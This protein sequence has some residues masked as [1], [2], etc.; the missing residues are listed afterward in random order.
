MFVVIT[1]PREVAM[2]LFHFDNGLHLHDIDYKSDITKTASFLNEIADK[3]IE[4]INYYKNTFGDNCIVLRYEDAFYFQE[5]FLNQTSKFLDLKSLNVDDVRKYKRSIYKNV[6]DFNQFFDKEEL[7][8]HYKK[9]K[10]FYEEWE[11][12]EGGT[13][14]Q[15]YH[16][17]DAE[18]SDKVKYTTMLD[19]NGITLVSKCCF[20]MNDV[21]LSNRVKD[22]NEF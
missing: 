6:G 4:L 3:Q 5:K 16:W 9:Y 20:N 14:A 1:D 12:P 17:C 15:K 7:T 19:R 8:K 10:S 22:I 11:Y 21:D 13:Q 18:S 2:N